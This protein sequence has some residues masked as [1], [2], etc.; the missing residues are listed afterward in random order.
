MNTTFRKPNE[1]IETPF[2]FNAYQKLLLSLRISGG[3]YP[4]FPNTKRLAS[5]VNVLCLGIV[6][7]LSARQAARVSKQVGKDYFWAAFEDLLRAIAAIWATL[8]LANKQSLLHK[9]LHQSVSTTN[10]GNDQKGPEKVDEFLGRKFANENRCK[11]NSYL[12]Y[13]LLAFI[14]IIR[15]V[16]VVHCISNCIRVDQYHLHGDA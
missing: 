11:K 7:V 2:G 14:S 1:V 12:I 13:F 16:M 15:L 6:F 5:V 9:C 10:F 8:L 3:Y 4:N